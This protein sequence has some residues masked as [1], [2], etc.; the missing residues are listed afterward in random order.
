MKKS[1]TRKFVS[2]ALMAALIVVLQCL[3]TVLPI[4]IGPVSITLVLIPVVVGACAYGP[5]FGAVLGGVFSAVVLIF[6]LN[7]M[8]A[9]AY[10]MFQ[11]SPFLCV[12]LIF[13]KGILCGLA[14]G[15][16]YKYAA[17]KNAGAFVAAAICPIVN[18]G[19]F[20][21]FMFTVF[22]K[23]LNTW[24]GGTDAVTYV[25]SGIVLLNFLPEFGLNLL[26]APAISRVLKAGFRH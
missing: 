7:G 14:A 22:R 16:C 18:T 19:I 1:N 13:G 8:D 4:K 20:L 21:L 25:L 15:L 26:F 11:A 10:M 2:L 23:I 24:A 5:E 9:G 12:L 17:N 6:T 3:A